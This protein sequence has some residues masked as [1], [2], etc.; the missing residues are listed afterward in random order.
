[1]ALGPAGDRPDSD[2]HF[3]FFAVPWGP[4]PLLICAIPFGREKG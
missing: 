1:L 4:G 3:T 2:G